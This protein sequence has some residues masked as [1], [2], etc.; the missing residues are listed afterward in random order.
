MDKVRE[1][2]VY[3]QGIEHSY[4]FKPGVT[5][6][7][8]A[9]P[10][11]EKKAYDEIKAKLTRV[12]E[13]HNSFV[14]KMLKLSKADKTKLTKLQ[15]DFDQMSARF[16]VRGEKLK[17]AEDALEYYADKSNVHWENSEEFENSFTGMNCTDF[18]YIK[19]IGRRYQQAGKRAHEA[20]KQIKGE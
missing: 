6:N 2:T 4:Y 16:T 9:M 19:E 15:T 3:Y 14:N 1:L 10:V 8:I 17:I 11:I 20:L 12:E 18:M 5:R 13:I 7:W